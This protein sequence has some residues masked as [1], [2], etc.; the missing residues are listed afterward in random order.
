MLQLLT[1]D[2]GCSVGGAFQRNAMT[3][4]GINGK[5][6]RTQNSSDQ[7]PWDKSLR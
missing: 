2:V 5:A 7:L 1:G 3:T 6:A 4:V